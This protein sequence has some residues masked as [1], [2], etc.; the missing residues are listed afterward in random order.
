MV[1]FVTFAFAK[2]NRFLFARDFD[3]FVGVV[4]VFRAIESRRVQNIIYAR[5]FPLKKIRGTTPSSFVII[6]TII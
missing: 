3:D 1:F 6:K 4:C 5:Y 2:I